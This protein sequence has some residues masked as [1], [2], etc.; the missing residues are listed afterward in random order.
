MKNVFD[1]TEF[2]AVGDNKTDCTKAIQAA[3]NAAKNIKGKVVVPPGIYKCGYIKTYSSV[4]LEG[5]P[6][7]G[8]RDVGGSVFSLNDENAPCLLDTTGA[9]GCRIDGLQFIGNYLG[10]NIC[11]VLLNYPVCN[12]DPFTDNSENIGPYEYKC[13]RTYNEDSSVI[14]NCQFTKFSGDGIHL[15]HMFA[16]KIVH[17]MSIANGGD[18]VYLNGWDGWI[19]DCIFSFNKGAGIGSVKPDNNGGCAVS[20]VAITNNRIEWNRE[21]GIHTVIADSLNINNNCFD[22]TI[23]PAIK[24]G[25]IFNT[26]ITIIGNIFRRCGAAIS[27]IG[28]D[29]KLIPFEDKYD[30][31]HIYIKTGKNIT[32]TGNIFACGKDDTDGMRPWSPDYSI[33]YQNL[34]NCVV[35]NNVLSDGCML[36][37]LV[38]LGGHKGE[39]II[40]NNIGKPKKF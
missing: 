36:E 39:N 10:S 9:H 40:N 22:R 21:C 1:I 15:N 31:S 28:D 8:Y 12:G 17:S 2:G 20:A 4:T 27:E 18:G 26:N 13:H 7:W 19:S 25:D 37:N 34:E 35:S 38:D 6:G 11:G 33:V 5:T 24:L 30:C 16:F 14:S 29:T 32:L 23:G 3:L